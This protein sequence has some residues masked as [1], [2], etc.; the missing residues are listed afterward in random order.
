M[1]RYL[2]ILLAMSLAALLAGC[3]TLRGTEISSV[4]APVK[5]GNSTVDVLPLD[6]RKF[7]GSD[8]FVLRSAALKA[9]S[10]KGMRA[11]NANQKSPDYLV[12]IDYASGMGPNFKYERRLLFMMYDYSTGKKVQHVRY[13][14]LGNE[15]ASAASFV[16]VLSGI[17]NKVPLQAGVREVTI[18]E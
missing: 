1:M 13:S 8:F 10:T 17:I 16:N 2:K 5:I 18:T 15:E 14:W 9:L 11:V 12:L 7:G 3:A 4:D 6:V